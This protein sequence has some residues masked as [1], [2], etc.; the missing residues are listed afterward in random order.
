MSAPVL[1]CLSLGAGVQSTTLALMAA[2]GEIGPMPDCA[3]FA[4]TQAEPD[5]VYRW[6]DWLETQLPFPVHRV[7]KGNLFDAAIK[8]NIS[9]KGNYWK[10]NNPPMFAER[11]GRPF[12]IMR[13]NLTSEY[14]DVRADA[15]AS[16]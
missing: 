5:S 15:V 1:R 3:I 9:K 14:R 6:L 8:V 2:K 13:Q 7:T 11:D 16:S 12:P 4:D 10:A